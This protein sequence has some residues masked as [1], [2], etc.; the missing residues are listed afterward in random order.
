MATAV[1]KKAKVK[2]RNRK[3]KKSTMADRVCATGIIILAREV[4][5]EGSLELR[6]V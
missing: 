1:S 5:W 2:G 4:G 3:R 6:G